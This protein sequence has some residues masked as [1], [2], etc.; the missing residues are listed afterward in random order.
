MFLKD[1]SYGWAQNSYVEVVVALIQ[2]PWQSSRK[3]VEWSNPVPRGPFYDATHRPQLFFIYEAFIEP[4]CSPGIVHHLL[5][6][7]WWERAF[8]FLGAFTVW[9]SRC[10]PMISGKV[11]IWKGEV[12]AWKRDSHIIRRESQKAAHKKKS[13]AL[14]SDLQGWNWGSLLLA[15][16]SESLSPIFLMWRGWQHPLVEETMMHPSCRFTF[17][18]HLLVPLKLGGTIYQTCGWWGRGKWSD[19]TRWPP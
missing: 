16:D 18:L 11:K 15:V 4:H 8:L 12:L 19:T 3:A 6:I 7:L 1:Q 10:S 17:T 14:E 2:T 5:M 13:V 9:Y